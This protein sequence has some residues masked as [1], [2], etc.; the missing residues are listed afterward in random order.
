MLADFSSP[1]NSN[2]ARRISKPRPPR[3]TRP[4]GPASHPTSTVAGYGTTGKIHYPAAPAAVGTRAV[5]GTPFDRNKPVHFLSGFREIA[6]PIRGL[7]PSMFTST[8][9]P[10]INPVSHRA[11]FHTGMDFASPMGT[12]VLAAANG[13]VEA[14]NPMDQIYGNQ[15]ILGHGHNKETMYGHMEKFV[16]QPGEKVK[17][18]QVIGYVGST[19]WS[20]GPH[21]HFE[22][23]VKGQPVNPITFLGGDSS[24]NSNP[25][26][27]AP[28]PIVAT[29]SMQDL[30]SGGPM[31][32]NS[33]TAPMINNDPVMGP[34]HSSQ[35][36]KNAELRA[37]LHAISDQE[38]NG[39]Y[40]AVGTPTRYGTAL[41]RY[42][43]L[44]SNILGPGGW[45][46]EELGYN[47]SPVDYLRSPSLQNQIARG[48]LT[49]YFKQYGAAG[50]AKA[51][52][53]GPGAVDSNSTA[54]QYGGPS[55]QGYAASVL[56]HMQQ[57]L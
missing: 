16:V 12:P 52:Y 25:P 20:T 45:D 8:Y 40:G 30:S 24:Q 26:H 22:T 21:L 28:R 1:A 34:N 10:R 43:V 6:S 17:E 3:V 57:Y 51:W 48:K 13:I 32:M 31:V 39:N 14:A 27:P 5:T 9:G 36:Y 23:H 4:L 19:G 2:P 49:E 50:A 35:E 7:D 41:G 56:Q 15:V 44:D 37:F 38:S 47:I 54:P 46:K 29:K 55:I 33:Q 42:Q 11:S 18:G 53:G